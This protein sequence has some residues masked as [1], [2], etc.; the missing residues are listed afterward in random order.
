MGPK[1]RYAVVKDGMVVNAAEVESGSDWSPGEGLEL[2]LSET[3]SVGWTWN[4][5]TF[6]EP[7]SPSIEKT[8]KTLFDG[9]D[10]LARITD[11]EYEAILEAAARSVQ[12][13]RWLDIFR[14]RGEIDVTGTTSLAAKAG[15]VSL[16]LLSQSRADEIF[17]VG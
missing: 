15:L 17:A 8:V 9:A 11:Q 2:I 13:A 4:G 7:T 6:I 1:M 16:G 14:L 5:Q 12:L 10:F 3:A